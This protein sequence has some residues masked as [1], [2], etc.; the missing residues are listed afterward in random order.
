MKNICTT[1]FFV[2]AFLFLGYGCNETSENEGNEDQT[3]EYSTDQKNNTNTD[4]DD[5]DKKMR[6]IMNDQTDDGDS[7]ANDVRLIQAG[8]AT[9]V[10]VDI[11][12]GARKLRLT[13][14]SSELLIAGFIYSDK[15]W[16]PEIEYKLSGKTGL[17]S[18]NQPDREEVNFN[19][20]DKYIWNLKFNNQIPLSFNIDLG[21]GVSEIKIGDLNI[22]DF[23]MTMGVGKTEVDLRGSWKKS[24]TIHLFGGIGLTRIYLPKNVG[25]R[26]NVD[27]GIGALDYSGL[28]QKNRN[29]YINKLYENAEIVLTVNMK[30]GIGKIEVE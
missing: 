14:G 5:M 13:G 26:L 2:P 24:T 29:V 9:N 21:A 17:L 25:I 16:K 7:S 22:D 20:D 18:I 1:L 15:T 23:S 12:I 10:D 27:K 30:T 8:A 4:F 3:T 19:N 6:K 11:K 28:I